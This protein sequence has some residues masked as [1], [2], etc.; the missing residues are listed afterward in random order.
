MD[1]PEASNAAAE[2]QP[3]TTA[4]REPSQFA[5]A[6]QIADRLEE[7]EEQARQQVVRT[8]QTLG[9]TQSLALLEET[10]QV[11]ATGGMLLPDGSRRRTAGG[12]F[13]FLARTKGQ[14]KE[15][16]WLKTSQKR[17]RNAD[18]RAAPSPA[19]ASLLLPVPAAQPFTWAARIAAITDVAEMR[20]A[21]NVKITLIGKP[22]KVVEKGTC[23]VTVMEASKMPSLPKGLPT[24]SPVSTTYTVYIAAKQW[25]KVEDAIADPEDVLI[26]EGFPQLDMATSSIAVFATNTTTKKLQAAQ[27]QAPAKGETT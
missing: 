14:P 20:G 6:M 25:R 8:V 7:T 4:P 11:E 24:P 1:E 12:V 3:E 22:G 17:A 27:R 15:R 21:A 2:Q 13:F 26:I 23:F 19:S 9:R 18:V 10:L 16:P 5:V